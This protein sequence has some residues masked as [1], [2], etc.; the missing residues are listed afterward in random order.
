MLYIASVAAAV[1]I[2]WASERSKVL[3]FFVCLFFGIIGLMV[4]ITLVIIDQQ[5]ELK[6]LRSR[7]T[8]LEPAPTGQ[9]PTDIRSSPKDPVTLMTSEKE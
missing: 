9:L 3:W 1:A 8:R 2:A 6:M 5:T 7:L 4:Q